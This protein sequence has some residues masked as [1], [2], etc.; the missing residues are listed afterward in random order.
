M[1]VGIHTD[2]TGL[3]A[4]EVPSMI[5]APKSGASSYR[6]TLPTGFQASSSMFDGL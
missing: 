5:Q 4:I 6:T 3:E 2:W 1:V